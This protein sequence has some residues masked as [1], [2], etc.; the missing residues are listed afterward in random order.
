VVAPLSLSP[1]V[2]GG[3]LVGDGRAPPGSVQKLPDLGSWRILT[4]GEVLWVSG[5]DSGVRWAVVE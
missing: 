1:D 3:E 4:A 2:C 5:C